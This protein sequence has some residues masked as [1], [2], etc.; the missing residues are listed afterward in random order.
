MDMKIDE[1]YNSVV[2]HLRGKLFGGSFADE[3]NKALHKI[4]D[5]GKKNVVL[6]L[7][8]VTVLNSTGF[9]ILVSSYTTVQNAGGSLKLARI[10]NKIEGLLSITKLNQIFEQYSTVEEAVESYKEK[11]TE[12]SN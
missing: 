4:L 10:S 12:P 3:L 2:V 9:G 7:N 6:D 1:E 8:G 5:E 11:K